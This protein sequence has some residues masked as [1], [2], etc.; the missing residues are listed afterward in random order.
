M[1]R[2]I[3]RKVG[4]WLMGFYQFLPVYKLGARIYNGGRTSSDA[5]GDS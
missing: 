3:R 4:W 1:T 5:G 2:F